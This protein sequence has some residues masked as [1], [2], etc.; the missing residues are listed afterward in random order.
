M[1]KLYPSKNT[2]RKVV[3]IA[4]LIYLLLGWIFYANQEQFLFRPT[5]IAASAPLQI[6]QAHQEIS[7]AINH[8]D[9]IHITRFTTKQ[10]I[11]GAILYFHGNRQNV[12]WYAKY[13]SLFTNNGYEVFMLDYPGYGKSRGELTEEKIYQWSDILY[14]IVRKSYTPSQLIIYGKSL[15]SGIAAQLAAKRDCRQLILETPYYD[16]PSVLSFYAPI[17][18]FQK[19]LHY[20]FPTHTFLEKVT[21]PVL[22]LH[23]TADG[24]VRYSNSIRLAKYFKNG[25]QLVTIENGN[26]NNLFDFA[27]AKA[28]IQKIL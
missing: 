16:F 21:A 2:I 23:G 11:Q 12:E 8:E 6:S 18:P 17:Y 7:I 14:S 19:L 10:P 24:V 25:D 3:G 5:L 13:S 9:T 27:V 26:H 4:L 28:A 15:G 20:Q 1:K 22:V